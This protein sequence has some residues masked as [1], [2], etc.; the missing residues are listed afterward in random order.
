M[1]V[2]GQSPKLGALCR[3]VRDLDVVSGLSMKVD[4]LS[5]AIEWSTQ[6]RERLRVLA[7]ILRVAGPID[8]SLKGPAFSSD[9]IRLLNI[10]DLR[11]DNNKSSAQ[12]LPS[13]SI[14]RS[15]KSITKQFRIIETTPGPQRKPPNLHPA[16][17]H[18]SQDDAILL[19]Q[20]TP[21][22]TIHYHPVVPSLSLIKDVLSI[23]ECSSIITAAQTIGFTPDAPIMSSREDASVLAHNFYWIIDESLAGRLWQRV[24]NHLPEIVDGKL[25][26]GLNR[27]FRVY[28]YV[29]GAEYRCHI[30]GAWPPSGINTAD[31]SYIYDSSPPNA[32][33]SSLYTFLLYLNDDFDAGETTFFMPSVMEDVINAYPVKPVAGAAAIFPHGEG[34]GA[35]LPLLHEGSGV[36]RGAKYIIRTDVLYDVDRTV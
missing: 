36:T 6:D 18:A 3:W 21:P 28:R 13:I 9:P 23:S 17:L 1:R 24:K 2:R 4:G 12:Q 27:R 22:A 5:H 34:E 26:R 7:M 32:K 19:S 16:I 20:E 35:L 31:D 8:T 14:Q 30:D 15:P 25:V 33:Q 29:P 10:W 11:T